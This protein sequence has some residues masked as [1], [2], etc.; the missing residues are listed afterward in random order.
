MDQIYTC[1]ACGAWIEGSDNDTRN[2]LARQIGGIFDGST[3]TCPCGEPMEEE[4]IMETVKAC[5]DIVTAA[6]AWHSENGWP[7]PRRHWAYA[8]AWARAYEQS[9]APYS[10]ASNRLICLTSRLA[11][12]L[13]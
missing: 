2:S 13:S 1:H 10:P 8:K 3:I 7:M 5:H 6:A 9:G 12:L 4:L 11:D